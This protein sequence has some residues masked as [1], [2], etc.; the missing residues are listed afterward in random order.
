M[1]VRA[2]GLG[3][4]SRA[5]RGRPMT[6]E[7]VLDTALRLFSERGY[8]GV[9]VEDI[10]REA[11]V[12]RAT[13]YKY[14][15]EREEILATLFQRL[16]GD[17][18]LPEVDASGDTETRIR[19]VAA[20]AVR[21]M[22]EQEQLA[23]FVYSLPV[24]HSALLDPGAAATPAV[25]RRIHQLVA[26]GVAREDLRDDVA[27]DVLCVHVHAA[28]ETAMRDWA[29]GRVDDPLPQVGQLLDLAF[30]GVARPVPQEASRRRARR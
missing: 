1:T 10:A 29:E 25:F 9:R 8:L 26:D 6:R 17:D 21:Q 15:S 23:R 5:A 19:A 18:A 24:R 20:A 30:H 27:V 2:A 4:V 12:S 11:G 28:V 14:F 3:G 22:L 16:L 7:V 13:F